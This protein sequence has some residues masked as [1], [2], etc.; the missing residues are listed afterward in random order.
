ME[1]ESVALEYKKMH[2]FVV[3]HSLFEEI[4]YGKVSLEWLSL[5]Y[6]LNHFW[7]P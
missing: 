2:V 3:Q 6:F 4:S 1:R 7:H 5:Y